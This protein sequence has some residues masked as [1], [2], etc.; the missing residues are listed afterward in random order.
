MVV[1]I[2]EFHLLFWPEDSLS[3]VRKAE[4]LE[5]VQQVSRL[6]WQLQE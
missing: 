3:L 1:F 4:G 6:L 2:A 5:A